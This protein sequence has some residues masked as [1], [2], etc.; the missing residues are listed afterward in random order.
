MVSP[1]MGCTT[2]AQKC[3][4]S[5]SYGLSHSSLISTRKFCAAGAKVVFDE[6]ECRVYYNNALVLTGTKDR[7]TDLWKLPINPPT[8]P[9]KSS[10]PHM[11]LHLQPQQQ[12]Q[13]G[14]FN[15]YTIP[16]KRNQVK[17]MHQTF[18]NAP[19]ATL[20][21]AINNHQLEDFPFLK[22]NIITKYLATSPATS[23]G[24][25]KHQ[26]Q[27]IRSTRTKATRMGGAPIC[28]NKHQPHPNAQ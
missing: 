24:R 12:V 3:S 11:D 20:I 1:V 4:L 23:K 9:C 21:H 13:H 16:H 8:K 22:A 15:V 6:K 2:G 26:R 17:Y 27:G 7:T 18:L 28:A 5:P 10:L 14:A 25:M 19:I